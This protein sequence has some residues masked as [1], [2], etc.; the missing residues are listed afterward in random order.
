MGIHLC[1][2]D[3][4]SKDNYL[5]ML[6]Q[7]ELPIWN[8]NELEKIEIGAVNECPPEGSDGNCRLSKDI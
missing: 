2:F 5:L 3:C 7:G 4:N 6:L 8:P 1:L